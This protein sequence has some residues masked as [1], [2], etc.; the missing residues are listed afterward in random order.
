ML[1]YLLFCVLFRFS[2]VWIRNS[3][4]ASISLLW[5]GAS[6]TPSTWG[7]WSLSSTI[8]MMKTTLVWKTSAFSILNHFYWQPN[9]LIAAS[10][11][12]F[13]R[14]KDILAQQDSLQEIVQLVGKESRSEDQKVCEWWRLYR[15]YCL[16]LMVHSKPTG[17]AG[18]CR[19]DCGGFP[20]PKC[21]LSLRF[22]VPIAEVG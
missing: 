10:R 19:H 6:V 20:L 3:P 16:M 4:S 22:H 14:A 15:S 9:G 8:T 7:F 21:L 18:H 2:G 1:F 5:T 13:Y 11:D 12:G 17:C